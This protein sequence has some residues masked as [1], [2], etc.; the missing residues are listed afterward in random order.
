MTRHS[1]NIRYGSRHGHWLGESSTA[2]EDLARQL[3]ALAAAGIKNE[4]IFVDKKS[5]ATTAR[6]GLQEALTHAG[7]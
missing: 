5:G 4:H 1:Y 7:R 6:P 2:K 3:D